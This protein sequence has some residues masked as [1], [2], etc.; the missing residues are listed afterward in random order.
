MAATL[1]LTFTASP[2]ALTSKVEVFAT[3]QLSQGINIPDA[4]LF[5]LVFVSGAKAG[6]TLN[7]LSAYVAKFGALRSGRKIFIRAFVIRSNGQRSPAFSTSAVV[8]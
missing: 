7:I 5:R 1:T 3:A 6:P 4:N 8:V 2:V